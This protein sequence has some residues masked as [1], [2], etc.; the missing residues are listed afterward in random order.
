MGEA[1]GEPGLQAVGNDVIFDKVP[2]IGLSCGGAAGEFLNGFEEPAA[3]EEGFD[4]ADGAA[5]A[6]AGIARDGGVAELT[7]EGERAGEKTTGDDRSAADAVAEIDEEKIALGGGGGE[8][9]QCKGEDFLGELDG[10]IDD[11]GEHAA[12]INALGPV[13]IGEKDAAGEFIDDAG[14]ADQNAP[15]AAAGGGENFFDGGADRV[16]PLQG[17]GGRGDFE[18]P[19]RFG[20]GARAAQARRVWVTPTW[21]S[22]KRRGGN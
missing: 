7:G 15:D 2:G 12:E 5:A 3:G 8:F 20:G 9:T 17:G 4:A 19:W 14:Q 1:G 6:G 11:A 22:K 10:G 13:N 18:R 21:M 16:F